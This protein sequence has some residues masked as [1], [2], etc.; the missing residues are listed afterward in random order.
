MRPLFKH[1]L[2]RMRIGI[3]QLRHG[4]P[5]LVVL[6]LALTS[7]RNSIPPKIEVC[8]LD[9]YGG[10]DCVE[11]DGTRLY[12]TPSMLTNYWATSGSDE[13]NFAGWCY[14]ATQEQVRPVMEQIQEQAKR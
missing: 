12:R 13:A 1:M 7:C 2:S 14:Q 3:Q 4:K 9:G 10:G 5:L 11:P 8:I 6:A